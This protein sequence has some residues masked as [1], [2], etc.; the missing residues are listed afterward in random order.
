MMKVDDQN[1]RHSFQC[2]NPTAF[3]LAMSQAKQ[4]KKPYSK[5]ST[6]IIKTGG[7]DRRRVDFKEAK[8]DHNTMV[9]RILKDS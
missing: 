9:L 3:N 6:K 4:K 7:A 5:V 2:N 1:I 8:E